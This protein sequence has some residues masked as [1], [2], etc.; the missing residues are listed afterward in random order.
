[1]IFFKSNTWDYTQPNNGLGQNWL[2]SNGIQAKF[3]DSTKIILSK[4]KNSI[5]KH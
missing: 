3:S 2:D 4:A 5:R 1:M